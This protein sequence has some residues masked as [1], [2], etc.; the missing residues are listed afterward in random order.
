[1]GTASQSWESLETGWG[2]IRD[3]Q[4]RQ[5]NQRDGYGNQYHET[6]LYEAGRRGGRRCVRLVIARLCV[7]CRCGAKRRILLRAALRYPLGLQRRQDQS[8]PQGYP[9]QGD[10]RGE[11]AARKA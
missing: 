3:R 7:E 8:R 1:R 10:R 2:I 6:R 5:Q 11:R 4:E 9:A